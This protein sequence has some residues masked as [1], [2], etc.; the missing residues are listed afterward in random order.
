MT[1]STETDKS[2]LLS[3][4]YYCTCVEFLGDAAI[5]STSTTTFAAIVTTT[6]AAITAFEF[7]Q[8][9][10]LFSVA[11]FSF[12][13]FAAEARLLGRLS[14]GQGRLLVGAPQEEASL[15]VILVPV[16]LHEQRLLVHA[17]AALLCNTNCTQSVH[18]LG[19][20]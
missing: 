8:L 10:L 16:E 15:A 9:V 7:P 4:V 1:T 18:N 17:Q 2:L 11:L 6:T 12:R 3:V 14:G 13:E 19:L 20:H 5:V